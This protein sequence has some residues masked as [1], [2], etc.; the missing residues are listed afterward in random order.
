MLVIDCGYATATDDHT[1]WNPSCGPTGFPCPPVPGTA[2]PHQF[3]TVLSL[4]DTTV[5][6][7][8][9]CAGA[10]TPVLSAAALRDEVI[11]LLHPPALGVSPSTGTALVNLRTLFWVDTA[12]EV[13]LGRANLIGFPVSLRVHYD[14]T[15]FDFGDGSSDTLAATPGAAYDPAA[16]CGACSD[17]FGH[18]YTERGRLT[19]TARVYWHA[20]FR[21]GTSAWT[22]I[23][24]EVTANQPSRTTLTV[25]Q[26][27]GTLTAPR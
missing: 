24:G 16:D 4:A 9:W 14:R 1:H 15:E 6:I 10:S 21:I 18:N 25:K 22:D 26:S 7:A 5:P 23:P 17:R 3:I 19:V 11:R 13:D 12:S 2:Y 27:R 8:A 20:Q